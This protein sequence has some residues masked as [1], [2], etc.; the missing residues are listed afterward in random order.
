[1]QTF[2]FITTNSSVELYGR[3][4]N[5]RRVL[6]RRP[7]GPLEPIWTLW[8]T[9]NYLA[10]AGNR[11][12]TPQHS[13]PY[14]SLYTDYANRIVNINIYSTVATNTVLKIDL[15]YGQYLVLA[16]QRNRL[17]LLPNSAS[18]DGRG[19]RLYQDSSINTQLQNS[20]LNVS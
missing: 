12:T 5:T 13:T 3:P 16:L 11:T 17:Y 15:L 6:H 4:S 19:T 9:E 1:M 14:P 2:F 10:R 7:G 20:I 18:T 8:R